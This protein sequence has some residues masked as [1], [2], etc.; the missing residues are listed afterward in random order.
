MG[1]HTPTR[2]TGSMTALELPGN[3]WSAAG[4]QGEVWSSDKS[5]Q[6]YSAFEW[7]LVLLAM[8]SCARVCPSKSVNRLKTIFGISL[9]TRRYDCSFVLAAPVQTSVGKLQA[10]GSFRQLRGDGSIFVAAREHSPGDPRQLV[11]HGD[12]NDVLGC[13]GVECIEPGSDRCSVA[14]DPQHGSSCTM[15]QNLAWPCFRSARPRKWA[16]EQASRP[17]RDGCRFAVNARSCFCVNFFRTST[18]PA[19]PSATR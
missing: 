17:I 8:M 11:G 15:N 6:M 14:L 2:S 12:H 5:A 13:S 16:P 7:R 4:L 18:L 19:A 10:A 3:V 9:R 1:G